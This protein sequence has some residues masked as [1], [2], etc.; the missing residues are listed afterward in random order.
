[1]IEKMDRSKGKILGFRLIGDV[2]KTDYD[3]MVP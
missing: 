3:V 2:S 1:M